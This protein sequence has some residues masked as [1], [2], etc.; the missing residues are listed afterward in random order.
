MMTKKSHLKFW[1]KMREER[2]LD[3]QKLTQ[4]PVMA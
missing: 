1:V 3:V 4:L 2:W